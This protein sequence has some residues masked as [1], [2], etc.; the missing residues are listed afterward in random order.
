MVDVARLRAVLKRGALVTAAN[1]PLVL[2]QFAADAA[3]KLMLAIPVLGGAL[4]VGVVAGGEWSELVTGDLRQLVATTLEVLAGV[5][6]AL[7]A[8]VLAFGLVLAGGAALTFVIKAGT[9]TILVQA[10]RAA[11]AVER[12]PLRLAAVAAAKR[13]SLDGFL[14]GCAHLAGRFL[15]LGFVLLLVYTAS[16]GVYLLVLVWAYRS[17]AA[18]GVS[19]GWTLGTA[20]ATV[21]LL[22]W[23]TAVNL[24]YVLTQMVVAA[25]D[26]GLRASFRCVREFVRARAVELVS[27]FGVVFV[28]VVL[29]TVASVLAVAALGLIGF[30]PFFGLLA[31]PLQV[32]AWLLRGVLFQYLGLTALA[33]YLVEYR[34]YR[35]LE[36]A[37]TGRAV[38]VSPRHRTG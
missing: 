2:V 23:I 19:L 21:A 1:W 33:A 36:P 8:F 24:L 9:V 31:L 32:V 20:L 38:S 30:V 18:G 28:L 22:V 25:E 14:D 35:D 7:V 26:R 13:F 6:A 15:A 37:A 27:I 3:F 29:A 4:L 11:G 34:T 10:E 5:P 17:A 16:G 12:P